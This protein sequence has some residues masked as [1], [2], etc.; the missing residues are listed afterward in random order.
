[1]PKYGITDKIALM[2]SWDSVLVALRRYLLRNAYAT[3]IEWERNIMLKCPGM[4]KMKMS[5][6]TEKQHYAATGILKSLGSYKKARH[7][8]KDSPDVPR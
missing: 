8:R 2:E 4:E 5:L 1:M 3:M 6:R 7:T